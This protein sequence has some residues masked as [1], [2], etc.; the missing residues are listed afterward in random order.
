MHI[1][2]MLEGAPAVAFMLEDAWSSKVEFWRSPFVNLQFR[3]CPN[4][5]PLV[6]L[7]AAWIQILRHCSEESGK[8]KLG[9]GT[10]GARKRVERWETLHSIEMQKPSVSKATRKSMGIPRHWVTL[11]GHILDKGFVLKAYK[12]LLGFNDK[13]INNSILKMA[14]IPT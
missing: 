14:T 12:W 4:N 5:C 9:H 3:S 6:S 1:L 13:M 10:K 7:V 11:L 8:S 2:H